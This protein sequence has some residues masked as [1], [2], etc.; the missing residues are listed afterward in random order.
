MFD[1]SVLTRNSVR[2]LEEWSTPERRRGDQP[3]D[4]I[5]NEIYLKILSAIHHKEELRNLAL[6]CR[7]FASIAVPKLFQTIFIRFRYRPSSK[8]WKESHTKLY[9]VLHEG[10][11]HLAVS[12]RNYIRE[13][14]IAISS[15][16]PEPTNPPVFACYMKDLLS[17]RNL[18]TP[19][20]NF[21]DLSLDVL[22]YLPQL[23]SLTS[24][25]LN[26]CGVGKLSV[27]G[28]LHLESFFFDSS[29]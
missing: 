9:H 13:C 2:D 23:S 6:V 11:D 12:L 14:R 1:N 4:P 3:L 10:S 27:G 28:R 17:M 19:N 16:G 18:S 26:C 20:L 15:I 5:P 22:E 29:P 24:L 8:T 21:V 7:F 25:E